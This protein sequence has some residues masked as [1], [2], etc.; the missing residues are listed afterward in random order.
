M[1]KIIKNGTSRLTPK[2]K[3]DLLTNPEQVIDVEY[4]EC[5]NND[6]SEDKNG[7]HDEESGNKGNNVE[8]LFEKDFAITAEDLKL[9]DGFEK[10][11]EGQKFLVLENLKQLTLGNIKNKSGKKFKED[12]KEAGF[13]KKILKQV[14]KS[15]QVEKIRKI[16][17]IDMQKGGVEAHGETLKELVRLAN[18]DQLDVQIVNG[19]IEINFAS[20]DLAKNPEQQIIYNDFNK[21]ATELSKIPYEWSLPSAAASE[22]EKYEKAKSL[23]DSQCS[24]L[25]NFLAGQT[26]EGAA[27]LYLN[28]IDSKVQLNRFISTH[29]EAEKQIKEIKNNKI[30]L[31]AISNTLGEKGAYV[32][33]GI[34]GRTVAVGALGL[35]GAPLVASFIGGFRS[36]KRGMESI[37]ERDRLARYDVRD[38]SGEARLYSEAETVCKQIDKLIIRMNDYKSK[39]DESEITAKEFNDKNNACK[40]SLKLWL[41]WVKDKLDKGMINFGSEKGRIF[42]QYRLIN[43][44]A[45]AEARI[46]DYF[47]DE[48]WA[49]NFNIAISERDNKN[50]IARKKFLIKEI[51]KGMLISAGFASAGYAIKHYFGDN[52]VNF[53]SEKSGKLAR[54]IKGLFQENVDDVK[55]AKPLPASLHDNLSQKAFAPRKYSLGGKEEP[56]LDNDKYTLG[57]TL[58][59]GPKI[60]MQE[61]EEVIGVKNNFESDLSQDASEP[62]HGQEVQPSKGEEAIGVKNNFEL[63]LGQNNVPAQMERVMHMFAVDAMGDNAVNEVGNFTEEQAARSLNVAANLVKLAEGNALRGNMAIT[64]T[65][66]SSFE[67]NPKTGELRIKDYNE[68]NNLVKN[69]HVHAKNLWDN[70]SLHKGAAAY[71]D[72]IKKGT[73]TKIIEANGLEN[74]ISGHD[75][76]DEKIVDFEKS[77]TVGH[78]ERIVPIRP[79]ANAGRDSVDYGIGEKVD[80]SEVTNNPIENDLEIAKDIPKIENNYIRKVET[81]SPINEEKSDSEKFLHEKDDPQII[82]IV[83]NMPV[84]IKNDEKLAWAYLKI[85]SGN[86]E[87]KSQGLKD[88]FALDKMP[89]KD[90]EYNAFEYDEK[91]GIIKVKNVNN[92]EGKNILFDTKKNKIGIQMPQGYK[93]FGISFDGVKGLVKWLKAPS[94][95]INFDNIKKIKDLIREDSIPSETVPPKAGNVNNLNTTQEE[96]G[97]AVEADNVHGKADIWKTTIT[98]MNGGESEKDSEWSEKRDVLN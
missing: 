2:E 85:L 93:S 32:S 8:E 39:L 81:G 21:A 87:E 97:S 31:K 82:N 57:H 42:N 66:R 24:N 70:G 41:D 12:L 13:F 77:E 22:R 19:K 68:F 44:F 47:I 28:N 43:S 33:I 67:Y 75:I 53:V 96:I 3:G 55:G 10:L 51:G 30:L 80:Y 29:P 88:M 40:K 61:S 48:K 83:A 49:D 91:R 20:P 25:L 4:N 34:I 78:A 37:K 65:M 23:Y 46:Q 50:T 95:N 18:Q 62:N 72:D 1:E 27:Q 60:E 98:E 7:A 74:K 6:S 54:Y 45:K 84:S 35:V 14:S 86:S 15:Y 89:Q 38:E 59:K 90:L 11:S 94:E 76:S 56:V 36:G 69:L 52:I 73:W 58:D 71:L 9:I 17:A 26:N 16:T 64:D 63:K 79:Q 5:K 92:V